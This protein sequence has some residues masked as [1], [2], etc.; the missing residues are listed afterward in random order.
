[1]I[2]ES[3]K[4]IEAKDALIEAL[5]E[6]IKFLELNLNSADIMAASYGMQNNRIGDGVA[7]RTKITELKNPNTI[8]P[9][10][11]PIV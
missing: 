6:Y 10:S 7:L 2:T 3:L 5:E 1:M 11:H 8:S 4:Q 9:Q